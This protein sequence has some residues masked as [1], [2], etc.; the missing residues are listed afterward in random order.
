MCLAAAGASFAD[1]VDL[2]SFHTDMRD[3]PL[4]MQVRKLGYLSAPAAGMDGGRRP[5]MLGGAPGYITWKSKAAPLPV[6]PAAET[7]R[8]EGSNVQKTRRPR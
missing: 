1:V 3:L 4:F 6:L 2:T 5:H 7:N 8:A